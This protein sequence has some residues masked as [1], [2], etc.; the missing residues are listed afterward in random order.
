MTSIAFDYADPNSR[1]EQ[2][3]YQTLA[4]S[5]PRSESAPHLKIFAAA[6]GAEDFKTAG[7][8]SVTTT[9]SVTATATDADGKQ[10]FRINRSADAQYVYN[11]QKIANESAKSD[12][13]DRAARAAA[14]S[15]RLAILAL[16]LR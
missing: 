8:G 14:E 6:F 1:E 15:M 13:R 5:F 11:T 10:L 2:I 16:N 4:L 12:A 9:V 3:V 7:R